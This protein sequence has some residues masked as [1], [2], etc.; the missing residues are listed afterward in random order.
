MESTNPQGSETVS[1]AAARIFGMLD[2]Q[3]PDGQAEVRDEE[4]QEE[5]QY[6]AQAE[7]SM[8]SAEDAGE[9]VQEEVEEPQRFRVKVDNEE[10]EVDLDELIKGY[11]R[12]SDYTKKTQ[13]LAEQRKQV[14]AER[15]KI[16]E[17]AKLRETYAQRL[18]I[19]EQMLTQPEEDLS[20]LKDTDPIGYTV[21]VAERIERDKQLAAVRAER[22][23]VAARQQQEQQ[24]YLHR[25]LSTEAERLKAAI[26]EIG[27]EVKGEVVRKDIKDFARSIGFSE[28]ELSQVYDHRAV[29]AL[30]KAMQ[31]DKLMKG[32]PAAQKKVSEAPKSLRPG[33]AGQRVDKDTEVAKKL[34]KQLKSTGRPRDAAKI[35]ERFL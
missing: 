8:D 26:P 10:L 23:A 32:K 3:Q 2:P 30:Y 4:N 28:Q 5:V 27:D 13:S 20:E 31:Y 24:E 18:Q 25:H 6:E 14:E 21:K 29:L 33:V 15:Q 19:I 12:T 7:E 9:E 16:E 1:D 34:S 11:S 35:F 22:E 17:A